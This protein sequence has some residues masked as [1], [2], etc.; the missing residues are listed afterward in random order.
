MCR[1]IDNA[2]CAGG[3]RAMGAAVE[4]PIGFDPVSDNLASAMVTD[5]RELVD[6][7]LEAIERVRF[8]SRDYLKRELVVVAAHFASGHWLSY[9]GGPRLHN[10]LHAVV[11]HDWLSAL[12]ADRFAA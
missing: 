4:G 6:R 7:A 12:R 1:V 11:S 5:R 3:M 10:K 9:R 8:A 2:P